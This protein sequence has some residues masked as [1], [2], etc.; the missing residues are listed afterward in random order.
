[1][2]PY[3]RFDSIG[4]TF[5]GVVALDDVTFG[6]RAGSVHALMGENGAGKSTLLKILAGAQPATSGKVIL[7]GKERRFRGTAEA[8][9]AGISVIYQELHLVPEL[10]VAE[11]I[12]LGHAPAVAG[13]IQR[14]PMRARAKEFLKELDDTIDPGAKVGSLPLAQ[15][16][17]VEIAKALAWDARV[18]AF[19]EPT[20]S[21][22]A[23]ETDRL[24]EVIAKLRDAGRCILYVTHRMEEVYRICDAIT[25]LRDGKHILTRDD[26]Q[27]VTRDELV[28]AM[29]GRDVADVFAHTPREP[30]AVRLEAVG[31]KARGL[32]QPVDF[33]VRRA[34][35]SGCSA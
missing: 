33:S 11:N 5:P 7:D 12:L 21:L 29:V 13:L 10:T 1:M 6:V 17:I 15:R 27:Q 19:D 35:S 14:G 23:R 22:S 26:L 28:R 9:R 2:E 24:M 4:R 31:V 20:S 16:Q 8:L 32:S 18:I 3:L 30:G 34:K 25:V